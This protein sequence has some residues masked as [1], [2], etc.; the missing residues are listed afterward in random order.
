MKQLRVQLL[1]PLNLLRQ[2][3]IGLGKLGRS[4]LDLRL[5]VGMSPPEGLVSSLA[6][7]DFPLEC[8]IEFLNAPRFIG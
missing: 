2:L 3:P 6:L 5:Q 4:S 8:L 1:T 7:G